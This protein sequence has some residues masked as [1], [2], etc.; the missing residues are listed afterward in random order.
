ML[1]AALALSALFLFA[2]A[3]QA[4]DP[5]SIIKL[6]HKSVRESGEREAMR[7][8]QTRILLH[9]AARDGV[10]AVKK[11]LSASKKSTSKTTQFM[12][13]TGGI[14]P[15][16]FNNL[17]ASQT[18]QKGANLHFEILDLVVEFME[19]RARSK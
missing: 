19:K 5:E 7:Q 12:A 15:T 18:F 3:V 4:H 1:R 14:D 10:D 16:P 17:S 6:W 9:I 13:Q 2:P 8:V 11:I